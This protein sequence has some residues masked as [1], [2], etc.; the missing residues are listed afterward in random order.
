MDEIP[1]I[2]LP[3]APQWSLLAGSIGSSL[4]LLGAGAFLLSA[5]L[6]AIPRT[7]EWRAKSVLFFLGCCS[8]FGAFA[9]LAALFIRDQ[10]QFL[11]IYQHS[12]KSNELQYKIAAIWSGQQ[13]SFLLWACTSALFGLLALR[14]SG[15]YKRWYVFTFSLFLASICGILA[16]ETPFGLQLL[17]GKAHIPPDGVGLAP[18]LYNYWVVIHPPTIFLGF[19]SLTI[20]FAYAVSA[21]VSRNFDA[22]A[23]MVRPWA[24]VSLTLLGLGLCMGG[25]WAYET[26]GWGGFWAWDPVENV[27]F[28]PWVITAALIHGLI[29]QVTKGKWRLTNLLLAGLPFLAFVYGTFLTRAGFL[30]KV[31]VH[32]F[33]TMDR[34]AHKV[35]LTF[36]IT[37]T[38]G[39]GALWFSRWRTAQPLPRPEEQVKGLQREGAYRIGNVFLILL[40]LATAIG[41]SVPLFQAMLGRTAKVVEEHLYHTVLSWFFIP[42]MILMAVGPFISWRAMGGRVLFNRLLNVI[43]ISVGLLGLCLILFNHPALGLQGKLDDPILFPLGIKVKPMPWIMFLLGLCILAVVANLWRL[44]EVWRRAK[45]SAGAFLAHTGV[46]LAM[47]GLIVS[48]GLE[49]KQSYVVQEGDWAYRVMDVGLMHSLRL[50]AAQTAGF[51]SRKNKVL[52]EVDG[53]DGKFTARPALYY[54]FRPGQDPQ[55]VAWPHI[56]RSLTHDM[57][58]HLHPLQFE[59]GGPQEL[60]PGHRAEFKVANWSEGKEVT[61]QVTYLE[62]VREGEAGTSGTKFGAKLKIVGPD[63]EHTVVPKMAITRGMPDIE[64]A[65]VDNYFGITM[66]RMNAADKS[67]ILQMNY[68]SPVYPIDLFYK[69]MTGLVWL[70]TGI[71][72][73]G[74]FWSAWN[75]RRYRKTAEDLHETAA[76]EPIEKEEDAL[77]PVA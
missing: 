49:S 45:P 56:E 50:T 70:G 29:V 13:G 40:A 11:Y 17:H 58:L 59:A 16:Y 43:S 47:A 51:L 12:E 63:G 64:P 18:S 34:T 72:T 60:K 76:D 65:A 42:L 57:Y 2:D 14:G 39:F 30:D 48:R 15:Q 37:A 62:M 41:M 54:T 69:P 4:I 21:L 3:L 28:V 10:F 38:V 53:P 32:S 46:A 31:S 61:Y 35:L 26:L 44:M 68:R 71:L 33:A 20:L 75:R 24:L 73:I 27:S 36:L 74:G 22:W 19:G 55:P 8:L 25:F 23:Q 5:L 66:Q 7:S 6:A 52:I 9:A 77:V 1:K 67:V